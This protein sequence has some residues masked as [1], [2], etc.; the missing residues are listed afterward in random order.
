MQLTGLERDPS[1]Q[2]KRSLE[3]AGDAAAAAFGPSRRGMRKV[4]VGASEGPR[5]NTQLPKMNSSVPKS[6]SHEQTVVDESF[7]AQQRQHD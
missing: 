7:C 3:A 6:R 4:G 5:Q 1:R 2:G